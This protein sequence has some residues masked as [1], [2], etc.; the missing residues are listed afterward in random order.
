MLFT[1]KTVVKPSVDP[2]LK[3]VP[4]KDLF[5]KYQRKIEAFKKEKPEV[6]KV[7]NYI[8]E[9]DIKVMKAQ[10]D[11]ID[12]RFNVIY[13]QVMLTAKNRLI[14]SVRKKMRR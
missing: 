14:L 4:I 7:L 3:S 2:S 8:M 5:N 12:V 9:S 11:T 6:N 1:A 10:A 13:D